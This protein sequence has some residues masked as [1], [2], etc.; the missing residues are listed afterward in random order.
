M[1]LNTADFYISLKCCIKK[2]ASKVMPV[3]DGVRYNTENILLPK[4]ANYSGST[5]SWV[6]SYIQI[7]LLLVGKI[8]IS[9]FRP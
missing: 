8:I 4:L 2:S 9:I 5:R 6:H 1:E 7:A 3:G